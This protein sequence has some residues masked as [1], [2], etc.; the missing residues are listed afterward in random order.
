METRWKRWI[1][2]SF[3][4]AVSFFA[5]SMAMW[6]DRQGL[7]PIIIAYISGGVCA[8]LFMEVLQ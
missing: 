8:L 5:L 6:L 3:A 7:S 2:F 1:L 4:I